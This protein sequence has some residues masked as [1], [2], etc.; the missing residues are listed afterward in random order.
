MTILLTYLEDI[1]EWKVA[2]V[3]TADNISGTDKPPPPP[4]KWHAGN[5]AH[6]LAE[7]PLTYQAEAG[8]L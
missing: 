4:G 3:R 5:N 6:P 2:R 8:W 7:A 1:V